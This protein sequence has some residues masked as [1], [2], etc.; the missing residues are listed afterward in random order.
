MQPFQAQR[1]PTLLQ[2][3][4]YSHLYSEADL[5]E[6]YAPLDDA[7]TDD[8]DE[9]AMTSSLSLLFR[10]PPPSSFGESDTLSCLKPESCPKRGPLRKQCKL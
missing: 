2:P 10:P 6:L 8:L 3:H 4:L 7:L 5:A 1:Q 9:G